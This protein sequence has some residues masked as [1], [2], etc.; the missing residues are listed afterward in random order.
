MIDPDSP[1][2]NGVPWWKLDH[3][4]GTRQRFGGAPKLAAY[5]HFN[6]N[7]GDTFRM[8]DLRAALGDD[9]DDE[10]GRAEH[11]NRRLRTLREQGWEFTSYMDRVGQEQ[12]EYVLK[13]K[14]KRI[15]LRERIVRDTPSRATRRLVFERDLNTCMI[16]GARAAEEYEDEPG[17]S[18]RLTIG[19]RIPGARLA[20]ASPESLQAECSRCNETVRDSLPNPETFEEVR[21]AVSALG[22]TAKAELLSWMES[23]HRHRSRIDVAYARIRRLS[24]A[25]QSK[26]AAYLRE[27]IGN[28]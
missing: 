1:E 21:A 20:T 27:V 16:C 14:G 11:L 5:L 8:R 24:R 26:F 13:A 28:R 12:D 6:L 15:W 17:S 22:P 3:W 25:D 7:V 4:P 23:G 18:V 10:P 2:Y 19:H 9:G